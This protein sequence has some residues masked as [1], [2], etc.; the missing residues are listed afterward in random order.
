[1][2]HFVENGGRPGVAAARQH[3]IFLFPDDARYVGIF[4]H[5]EF[6]YISGFGLFQLT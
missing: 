4:Y 3:S 2:Y 6:D 5:E 1:V